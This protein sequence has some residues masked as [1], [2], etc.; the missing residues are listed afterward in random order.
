MDIDRYPLVSASDRLP[1][2]RLAAVF[3]L[4]SALVLVINTAKRAGV[5]PLTPATQLVAPLGQAL[6]VVFVVGLW[7]TAGRR[8]RLGV[9]AAFL[10]AV[11]LSALVGVE[12]ILNLVFPY[13]NSA[14]ITTLREGPLGVALVVASITFMLTT[15]LLVGSLL[16][17]GVAP[18]V[19]LVL[20]AV[21]VVPISLRAQLPP[22]ALLIGLAGLIIAI[23]WLSVWMFQHRTETQPS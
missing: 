3:G 11:S 17:T 20:Y 18:K 19:P 9:V 4:A 8:D 2:A 22:A 6:A 23:V 12:F 21:S 1:V 16:R 10:A 5:V 15:W 14:T 7:L 13:V